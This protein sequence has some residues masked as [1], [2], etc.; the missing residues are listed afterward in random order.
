[1]KIKIIIPKYLKVNLKFW[2]ELNKKLDD[3]YTKRNS[4][5]V[6]DENN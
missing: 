1:M 5:N 4:R 2:D 3:F 6:S